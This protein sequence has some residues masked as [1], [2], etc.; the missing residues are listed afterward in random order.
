M[1]LNY[2]VRMVGGRERESKRGGENGL[3]LVLVVVA[4]MRASRGV[5]SGEGVGK[6]AV[7]S[8]SVGR[9]M[10]VAHWVDNGLVRVERERGRGRE[11]TRRA[12]NILLWILFWTFIAVLATALLWA[13]MIAERRRQEPGN[14][15]YDIYLSIYIY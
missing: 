3:V 5:S 2:G 9:G 14:I 11:R 7:V 8:E 15:R 1:A 12:E 10:W 4:V 6:A 13:V